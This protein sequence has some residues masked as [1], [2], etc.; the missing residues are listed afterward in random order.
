MRVNLFSNSGPIRLTLAAL[1][2]LSIAGCASRGVSSD[3]KFRTPEPQGAETIF[4]PMDWPDPDEKRLATGEPG[5]DYWQQRADYVI[6]AELDAEA[7][8]LSA[9]MRVTY[10]NNS[11]HVLEYMWVQLEQNLFHPDS[12]GSRSRPPGG[13]MRTLDEP[14][15]GGFD[16]SNVRS[17]SGELDYHI[18]DT[19]MYVELPT[20]LA[21]GSRFSFELDFA[22][23]M[24]PSLRRMGAQDVEQGTIFE[25]AQWF[26]HV[27]AYDDVLGWNTMNYLGTGEFYTNFGTYEVNLTVPRDYLV[28]ATGTLTNP[29]EVLTRTQRQRLAEA[30]ASEESMYIRAPEEVS[31]PGSRPAGAGPLTWR[32]VAD[33]VRTFA[34][35]AS[36]AFI[37]DAAGAT[38]TDLDG[39]ERTVLCQSFYPKEA[40]VW[41]V[42]AESGGST[43]YIRHAI[44]FY[45]DF[46]YPYP[47][48]QMS[49]INGP[50]GGM[51]YPMIIFCGARTNVRGLMG[52]TDHEV[53][54]NWFP[55]LVNTDERRHW[56]MDEGFNSFVNHYSNIEFWGEP[57]G[58]TD[59]ERIA[60]QMQGDNMQPSAM[61]PDQWLPE[62]TGFLGY[63]KPAFG[64][65]L[66]R[67]QIL[68]EER[69]DRA[70]REYV[71]RWAFKAPKPS[72]FVRTMEDV[73]GENL[74]WF[75]RG[76]IYG[77]GMLDQAVL[78]VKQ[79]PDRKW[80]EIRL[81]NRE[82]LVMPVALEIHYKDGST[83]RRRVPVEA[84]YQR[85]QINHRMPTGGKKVV[86]VH[87]DP[88]EA[89]PDINRRNNKWGR[90]K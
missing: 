13:P 36:D 54:H 22:F 2:G 59:P 31:D 3:R 47:Y 7:Q 62:R 53:A 82:E 89:F 46:L 42:G 8:R 30:R 33:D 74:D 77:T 66:L 29:E 72:D 76:W 58:R 37:W 39:S 40:E 41:G 57:R 28:A 67:E 14:F 11:P 68:G 78:G 12:R 71:R 64:L 16:L 73:A 51:E 83:E 26:P 23:D 69:F 56:W 19:L 20:P 85:N 18:D 60:R 84:W 9:S 52:V 6:D 43:Q 63:S 25:Y 88:D 35:A 80:A 55:M 81:A 15:E 65:V 79:D 10:H 44:E 87:I 27:C 86:G 21:P 17:A 50:E 1:L 45:S 75:W 48:P 61:Y 24:P 38:I 5:P 32:F 34:W 90:T 4:S 70:F 49:N